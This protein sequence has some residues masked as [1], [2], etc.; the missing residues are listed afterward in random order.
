M[1]CIVTN[2]SGVLGKQMLG[3]DIKD[4]SVPGRNGL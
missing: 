3:E 2:I 4:F 1:E